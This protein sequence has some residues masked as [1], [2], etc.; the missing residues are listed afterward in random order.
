ME[1]YSI[2]RSLIRSFVRSF[3]LGWGLVFEAYVF[4]YYLMNVERIGL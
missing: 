1:S 3:V 4:N 2:T